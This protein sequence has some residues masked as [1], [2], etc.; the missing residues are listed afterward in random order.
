MLVMYPRLVQGVPVTTL[1]PLSYKLP[2]YNA[3]LTPT[4]PVTFNVPVVV[5]EDAVLP[6]NDMVATFEVAPRPV[7]VCSVSDS[8]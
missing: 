4:P 1:F 8:V 5:L 3:P 7:T 2:A 6:V